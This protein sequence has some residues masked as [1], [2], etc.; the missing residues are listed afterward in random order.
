MASL[1]KLLEDLGYRNVQTYIQSGNGVF[2]APGPPA[3]IFK[4][5]SAAL[6]TLMG[7]PVGLVLRTHDQLGKMIA[8]NPY[9][10]EALADGSCVFAV[11]LTGIPAEAV[12][13]DLAK[14]PARRDRYH[15]LEDTLYLH[16][17][18]GAG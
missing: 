11:F 2:D 4:S 9:P 14:I 13:P 12:I 18:D 16:L 3:K 6:E 1:R 15:L 5:I 17:P 7:S 8:A 10:A